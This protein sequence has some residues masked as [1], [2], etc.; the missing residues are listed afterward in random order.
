MLMWDCQR[1]FLCSRGGLEPRLLPAVVGGIGVGKPHLRVKVGCYW[2]AGK[3]K[4]DPFAQP[5]L[6]GPDLSTFQVH[7]ERDGARLRQLAPGDDAGAEA[8]GTHRYLLD[9]QS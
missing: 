8:L 3:L 4:V 2:A 7:A 9:R 1:G 5:G 6:R